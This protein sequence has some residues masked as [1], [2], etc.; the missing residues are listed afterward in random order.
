[1]LA[2][3]AHSIR[4]KSANSRR[5]FG[6][7]EIPA[8]PMAVLRESGRDRGLLVMRPSS[9]K[10]L[11]GVVSKSFREASAPAAQ[12]SVRLTLLALFLPTESW[13]WIKARV[14]ECQL[15]RTG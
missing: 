11:N 2:I 6:V 14:A 8:A 13:A 12:P 10:A 1:M 9:S 4:G 5:T 3:G 15:R 7:E